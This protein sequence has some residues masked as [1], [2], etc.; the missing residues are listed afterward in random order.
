MCLRGMVVE[1]IVAQNSYSSNHDSGLARREWD[2]SAQVFPSHWEFDSC[3]FGE[4]WRRELYFSNC[5][6]TCG[7]LT[8]IKLVVC[9]NFTM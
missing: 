3:A 5:Y 1:R 9:K 7:E 2:I 8:S 6:C 4:W